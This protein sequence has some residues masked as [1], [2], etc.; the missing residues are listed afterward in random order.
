MPA[1]TPTPTPT[2]TNNIHSNST[3]H[4]TV[5]THNHTITGPTTTTSNIAKDTTSSSWG[6]LKHLFPLA[7]LCVAILFYVLFVILFLL[8]PTSLMDGPW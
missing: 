1:T 7:I 4:N 6:R 3:F 8:A 2:T 5:T